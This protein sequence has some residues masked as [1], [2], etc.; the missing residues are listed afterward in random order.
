MKQVT[1]PHVWRGADLAARDDW[2]RPIGDLMRADLDGVVADAHRLGQTWQNFDPKLA[3]RESLAEFGAVVR[4]DLAEGYGFSLLRNMPVENYEPDDLKIAYRAL[5]RH[6]GIAGAQ[7][8]TENRVV[9][10]IDLRSPEKT[11]YNMR[12]GPLPMHVDPV[13]AVGLLCVRKAKRGGLSGIA[14]SM[15]VHNIMLEECPEALELL[16]RGFYNLKRNDRGTDGRQILTDHLCPIFGEAGGQLI[17]SLTRSAILAA[18][19]AGRV[20]LSDEEMEALDLFEEIA[21]R[22]EIMLQMDLEPGDAQILNNRVIVH[23]RTDYVDEEPLER[24]RMLLRQWLTMPGWPKFPAN[25]PHAD[26]EILT[27]A[28]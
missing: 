4:R 8:D 6:I 21:T 2:M 20:N 24:R 7:G 22:P 9:E 1:G 23:N 10:V 15:M 13:D 18:V 16:Y 19:D 17:C 3:D 25:M 5:C 26:A 14:S 11:F 27:T 12:G 28:A